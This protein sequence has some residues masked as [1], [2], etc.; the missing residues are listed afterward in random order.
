[1]IVGSLSDRQGRK[2]LLEIG[3]SIYAAVGFTYTLATSVEHLFLI[4]LF[5]GAGSA[6]IVP[7][8]MAYI[9]DLAPAKQEG[10]YMGM[11]NIALFAGIGAGPMLGGVFRDT[12]GINSTFYAM[13]ALK[14]IRK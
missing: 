11:L 1:P 10:K 7:I 4:R 9:G 14:R 13:S 5:Y 8:V 2:R 12:I 3:L 6:M